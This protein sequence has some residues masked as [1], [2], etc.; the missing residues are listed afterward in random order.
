MSSPNH[1]SQASIAITAG[2]MAAGSTIGTRNAKPSGMS[3]DAR[4]TGIVHA[5]IRA[6]GSSHH[7]RGRTSG[8][9]PTMS[10]QTTNAAHSMVRISTSA[11]RVLPYRFSTTLSNVDGWAHG[12]CHPTSNT[13]GMLAALIAIS[14]GAKAR[15]ITPP[16]S[17]G[18]KL[19]NAASSAV[20][21]GGMTTG[22]RTLSLRIF[23]Q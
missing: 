7:R 20:A 2:I 4:A 16:S 3:S 18:K 13:T 9:P 6:P 10:H 8:N 17:H 22:T 12:S 5:V 11:L 15:S 19:A 21:D 23:G 14:L 1:H